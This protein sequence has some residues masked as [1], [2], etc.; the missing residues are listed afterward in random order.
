ML[1][2]FFVDSANLFHFEGPK[3]KASFDQQLFCEMGALIYGNRV[4]GFYGFQQPIET[5]QVIWT[6]V[7][8]KFE[9]GR[10]NTLAN[11]IA[12]WKPILFFGTHL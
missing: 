1:L 10:K 5:L 12:Y 8:D 6:S 7:T 2:H 11:S 9:S 3:K 4:L